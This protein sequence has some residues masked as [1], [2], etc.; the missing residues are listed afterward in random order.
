MRIHVTRPIWAA[1]FVLLFVSVAAAQKVVEAFAPFKPLRAIGK[2][3][4]SRAAEFG[5][6]RE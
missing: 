5:F 3:S 2:V 6:V 1:A 4:D